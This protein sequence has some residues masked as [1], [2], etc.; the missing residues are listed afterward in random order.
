MKVG[1]SKIKQTQTQQSEILLD[2]ENKNNIFQLSTINYQLSTINYQ[3]ST[4]NFL[5]LYLQLMQTQNKIC[6]TLQIKQITI[7]TKIYNLRFYNE[8]Y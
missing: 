3:L 2:I 6:P 5:Y 8:I 7:F 1:N 4:I